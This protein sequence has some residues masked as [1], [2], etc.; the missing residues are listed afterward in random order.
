MLDVSV[1]FSDKWFIFHISSLGFSVFWYSWKTW[2]FRSIFFI[3]GKHGIHGISWYF[4][5]LTPKRIYMC[6]LAYVTVK[7]INIFV[8]PSCSFQA[9][10][11][12]SWFVLQV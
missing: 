3:A 4:F 7:L 6:I 12:R 5:V 2:Y 11:S 1:R 8:V 9:Q 10:G